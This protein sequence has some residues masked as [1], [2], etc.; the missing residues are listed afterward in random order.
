MKQEVR[1][2]LAKVGYE[3]RLK[4]INSRFP[5]EEDYWVPWEAVVNEELKECYRVEAEAVVA[6]LRDMV[7]ADLG[8]L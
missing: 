5:L 4:H 1:E 8:L 3:A 2:T 7:L 6:S